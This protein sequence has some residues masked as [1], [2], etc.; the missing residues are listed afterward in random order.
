MAGDAIISGTETEE[1][2]A[3]KLDDEGDYITIETKDNNA[4]VLVYSSKRLDEPIA[5]RGLIVMNTEEELE[6][7]G[8]KTYSNEEINVFWNPELCQHAGECIRGNS[9]VFD[10]SRRPWVDISAAPSKE[11]AEI[12]DRCPS[13]ALL[14][15]LK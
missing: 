5:W 13:G 12:I 10:A 9:K 7:K 11:I 2:T 15:E 4:E 3:S 6:K 1:Q 14:Y 8:Y